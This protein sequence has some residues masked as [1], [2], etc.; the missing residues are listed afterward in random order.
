L[1]DDST[2]AA[3]IAADRANRAVCTASHRSNLAEL[4]SVD[5]TE[6]KL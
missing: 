2:A 6:C 4:G 1:R 5:V 3:R